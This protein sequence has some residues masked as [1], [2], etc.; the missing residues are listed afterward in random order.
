MN[1]RRFL[2]DRRGAAAVEATLVFTFLSVPLMLGSVDCGFAFNGW[3]RMNLALRTV[4]FYAWANPGAAIP[5][6]VNPDTSVT[7]TTAT[8]CYCILPTGWGP[9]PGGT[10]VSCTATCNSGYQVAEYLTVNAST[11]VTLPVSA[12][13]LSSPL[14]LSAQAVVRVQ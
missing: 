8:A 7:I 13:G 5:S 12:P 1:I 11:S 2:N 4:L 6:T 9:V 14:A 10:P 3:T